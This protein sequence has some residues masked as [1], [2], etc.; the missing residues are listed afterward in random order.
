LCAV[1]AG[2]PALRGGSARV[3]ILVARV[4]HGGDG[5]PKHK[6]EI[7]QASHTIASLELGVPRCPW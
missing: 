4:Q 2:L 5:V 6:F 3:S 7:E 1:S